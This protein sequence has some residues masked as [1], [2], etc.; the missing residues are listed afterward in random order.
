MK[1]V[2]NHENLDFFLHCMTEIAGAGT[3]ASG[4]RKNSI[5]SATPLIIA[6]GSSMF[7]NCGAKT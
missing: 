3:T 2:S 4:D 6:L 1:N 5:G 7:S